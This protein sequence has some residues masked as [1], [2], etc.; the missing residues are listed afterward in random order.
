MYTIRKANDD[1]AEKLTEIAIAS[2]KYW[3]YPESWFEEWSD[4]LNISPETIHNLDI[5]VAEN[6]SSPFG[7]V[8][9]SVSDS[10]AELEHLWVH[11]D[12]MSQGTGKSLFKKVIDYCQ[13]NGVKKIRIES[14]PNAQGFYEKMGAHQVGFVESKPKP[15]KLP[16]LIFAV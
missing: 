1:E 2:K 16:V 7:F 15:R 8:G 5:W 13:C 6:D 12:Y 10:V 14:D 3:N 4:V 11:P 9:I